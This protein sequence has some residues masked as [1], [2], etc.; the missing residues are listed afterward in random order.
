MIVKI[1]I[2]TYKASAKTSAVFLNTLL[3]RGV[4]VPSTN[5]IWQ[6]DVDT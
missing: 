5:E 1:E 3:T 6:N 2:I 4:E